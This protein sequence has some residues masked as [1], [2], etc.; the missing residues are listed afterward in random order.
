MKPAFRG[1][2]TIGQSFLA[3]ATLGFIM[4]YILLFESGNTIMIYRIVM[5]LSIIATINAGRKSLQ[6]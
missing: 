4:V 5:A 2:R 6:P 1:Q 3:E